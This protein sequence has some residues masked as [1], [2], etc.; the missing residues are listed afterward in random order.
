MFSHG[1]IKVLINFLTI[2]KNMNS[3]N[4]TLSNEKIELYKSSA[5]MYLKKLEKEGKTLNEEI[6]KLKEEQK[7]DFK[8]IKADIHNKMDQYPD[9]VPQKVSV[10]SS[11]NL[12]KNN[13]SPNNQKGKEKTDN[14]S[15]C[16][17]IF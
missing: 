5:V 2:E 16:C 3:N 9:S 13:K 12:F 11:N 10:V 4:N 14:T 6:A 17:R 7:K 15:C 8:K 1:L